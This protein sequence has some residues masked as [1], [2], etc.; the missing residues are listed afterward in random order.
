MSTWHMANLAYTHTLRI[1]GRKGQTCREAGAQSYGPLEEVA[2]LPNGTPGL[3]LSLK[4]KAGLR[5]VCG[6]GLSYELRREGERLGTFSIFDD[7]PTSE[8]C[9][10]RICECPTTSG[11]HLGLHRLMARHEAE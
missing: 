1:D 5:C 11:E 9:C 2:E 4:L 7:E 3:N 8:T 6:H 10:Q